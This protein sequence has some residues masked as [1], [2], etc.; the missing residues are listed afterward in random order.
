MTDVETLR[1]Q[2]KVE[3]E[4]AELSA[5]LIAL[6]EAGGDSGRLD[7]VKSRLREWRIVLRL[8]RDGWLVTAKGL[9]RDPDYEVSDELGVVAPATVNV[10]AKGVP[11]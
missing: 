3:L 6:K 11:R 9:E 2:H 1:E 4:V 5:E 10:K 7:E 8:K